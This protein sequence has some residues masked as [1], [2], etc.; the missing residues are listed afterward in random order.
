MWSSFTYH[1][2]ST[3]QYLILIAFFSLLNIF[4]WVAQWLLSAG[5]LGQILIGVIFGEP[6]A[7]WLDQSWMEAFISVGY[8]GLLLVVYEGGAS[9]SIEKL[10]ALLPLSTC[11]AL[12]GLLAPIALSFVLESLGYFEPVHAFAAGSSLCSTSLGTVLA[13]LS[14]ASIGFNLRQTRL[15]TALLSAAIMDD[16]VA[17]IL[18]KILGVIGEGHGSIGANVGRTIG[19]TIVL[20]VIIALL[21]KYA[22]RPLYTRLRRDRRWRSAVW[23]GEGLLLLFITLLFVGSVAAAGYAGTSPLYGAY[24][25]G[26]VTAY[27]SENEQSTPISHNDIPDAELYSSSPASGPALFRSSTYP[28]TS[29]FT[30]PG[31][32]SAVKIPHVVGSAPTL[33]SAFEHSVAPVLNLFLLPLFFGSIG[34][35]IPFVPLWRGRVIWRGVIYALLMLV[36][37]LLCGIWVLIWP[38]KW[39]GGRKGWK[40]AVFL[41]LAMVARGEIGL[42]ISQIAYHTSQ[43]LF[44]EDE[45][46]IVTWAIVI[47][48]IIGPVGVGL[49]ISRWGRRVLDGGWD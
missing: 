14:P 36:A 25:A 28:S 21:T 18:A 3:L 30:P 22:L 31:S 6:L 19:V 47:C 45:F 37:K 40:G 35:C 26:L 41:G 48:T 20:A 2:P 5:L 42:L 9:A 10:T 15:G 11:I 1:E 46:L 17:F 49:S 44:D 39:A 8:V 29:H 4:G 24:L 43:P 13:V 34:Y 33:S 7:G 27:L 23:G 16:V 38:A 12:T 32:T